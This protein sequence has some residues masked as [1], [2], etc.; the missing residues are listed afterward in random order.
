[1]LQDLDQLSA[2]LETDPGDLEEETIDQSVL[3]QI[4]Q[5]T[6]WQTLHANTEY[7]GEL[8]DRVADSESRLE[9]GIDMLASEIHSVSQFTHMVDGLS[10]LVNQQATQALSSQNQPERADNSESVRGILGALS[11]AGR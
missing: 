4:G 6:T 5:Q 8:R 3:H 1:M 11:R 9:I 2:T 7:A 10:K